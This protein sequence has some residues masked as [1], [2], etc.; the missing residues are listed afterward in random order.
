MFDQM[1]QLKNLMGMLGNPAEIREKMERLQSELGELV[2]EG[3]SGAGAVRVVVNGKMEVL[4][5]RVEP[6][7]IGSLVGEGLDA[8]REMVEELIASAVNAALRKAQE[9][10]KEKMAGLTGG[11]NLPGLEGLTG[12]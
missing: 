7:M 8:D 4:S 11:L 2:A 9:A 5:V 12:A 3:E 10:A 1:K 6:A